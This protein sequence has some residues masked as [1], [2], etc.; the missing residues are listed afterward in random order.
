MCVCVCVRYVIFFVVFRNH[1]TL[2]KKK[3]I[4]KK[5][6]LFLLV[7]CVQTRNEFQIQNYSRARLKRKFF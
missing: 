6:F 5:R 2:K 4:M 7:L 1:H 3:Q